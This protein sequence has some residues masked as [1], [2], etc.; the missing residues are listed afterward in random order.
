MRPGFSW[1][2]SRIFPIWLFCGELAAGSRGDDES[3][4]GGDRVNAA[5]REVGLA[6][7]RFHLLQLGGVVE[8][9]HLVARRLIAPALVD[10]GGDT[11]LLERDRGVGHH[12]RAFGDAG[13]D[14]LAG[15]VEV[16]DHLHAEAVL[17]EGDDGCGERLLAR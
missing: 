16:V 1:W 2:I 5:E 13:E 3:P 8:R 15:S 9:H 14:G 11:G 12:G 7:D 10:R 17:F 4:I 6:G